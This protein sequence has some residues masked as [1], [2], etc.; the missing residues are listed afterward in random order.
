MR[1]GNLLKKYFTIT[2]ASIVFGAG[3]SLFIDPN[4]LAPGGVSGL[5]IILNRLVPVET[6]TLFLLI[7]IPIILLGMWKFGFKF[8]FSTLYA[9][10][11]ISIFT[12]GFERMQ[13]CTSSPLLGAVFG[14][15]LVAA[16]IG[17]VMRAGGTTGGTDILV[18]CMKLK[19]PHLKTGTIFLAIDSVII[20]IGGLVFGNVEGVLY[21]IISAAA[22]SRVL[23]LILY[24]RDEARLIYIISN[25]AEA[26]T[27]RILQE[28]HT[29]VTYLKGAGAYK[30]EEKQIILCVVKKTGAYKVEEIV[31]QEDEN[32]FMIVSNA[33]EIYGEGYKSYFGEKL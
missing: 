25:Y 24:G 29:G 16:G 10:F 30:K 22:T 2:L 28:L 19:K 33:K 26:I 1:T 5:S 15:S 9:I 11:A 7:N 18:K 3:V 21:S 13:P 27:E 23:D 14:G 6:G 32:A 8:I 12:N 4:N 17:F 20:G 31:K